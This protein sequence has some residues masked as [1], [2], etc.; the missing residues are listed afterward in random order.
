MTNEEKIALKVAC[1]RAA[2]TMVADPS[3]PTINPAECAN[4]A[5]RIYDR[6]VKIDWEK[7]GVT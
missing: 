4:I 2:A 6:V 5:K 1:V 7:E 3:K